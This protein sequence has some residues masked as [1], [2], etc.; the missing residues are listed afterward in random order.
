MKAGAHRTRVD[1][2][3]R[4][5][6]NLRLLRILQASRGRQLVSEARDSG[7][8]QGFVAPLLSVCLTQ[9]HQGYGAEN[10]A[11]CQHHS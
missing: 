3:G 4:R 8:A 11:D 5:S 6:S 2:A 1:A 10:Q 7:S 9:T